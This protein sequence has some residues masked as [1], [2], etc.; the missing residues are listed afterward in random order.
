MKGEGGFKRRFS[1]GIKRTQRLAE[2]GGKGEIQ[3]SKMVLGISAK[4]GCDWLS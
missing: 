2:V 3:V 1:D 4:E